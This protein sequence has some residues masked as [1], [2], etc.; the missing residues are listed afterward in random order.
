[1]S[2]MEFV[3]IALA[4]AMFM[5]IAML[6]GVAAA[7]LA[8]RDGSTNAAALTRAGTAFATTP[9]LACSLVAALAATIR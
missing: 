3:A 1:M 9:T 4:S 7:Y 8:R 5:V 6:V 2:S